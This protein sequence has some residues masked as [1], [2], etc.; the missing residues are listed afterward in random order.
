MSHILSWLTFF[1]LI[2]AVVIAFMPSRMDS[3]VKWVAAATMAVPLVLAAQLLGMF[4]QSSTAF[5]LVEQYDWISSFNIQYHLGVDGLSILMVLLTALIS[6]LAIFASWNIK[7]MVKGYFI[8]LMLLHVGMMGCFLALDFFLFFVF[9]EVMLIPMYFLIGI[10]GGEK[11]EYAAIK[12]F[13]YTMFGGVFMLIGML[14]LYF[15]SADANG[16]VSTFNFLELAKVDWSQFKVAIF[17]SQF[18]VDKLVWWFLFLGFAVKVPVW[19]FHTWLPW[20]HVQAPTAVSIILAG[21]LLKLGTYGFLRVNYQLLPDA[22]LAFKYALVILGVIGVIYGAF[23]ALAQK[24]L[25]K[26][27]AYSSVSHMGYVL[28]GMA[29]LTPAGIQGAVLQMFNHGLSAAMMFMLVGVLYDRLHHRY[30]VTPEGKL[31]FGGIAQKAPWITAIWMVAVFAGMGLPGLNGF[32]SEALIFLG[33]FPVYRTET[34]IMSIGIVLGAAYLLWM[35]QRVFLGP[36]T[37]L[38]KDTST[39]ALHAAHEIQEITGREL[40]VLAPLG[41]LCLWV[42]VYPQPFINLM[43]NTLN[44]LIE[45]VK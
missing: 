33:S 19:P 36:F 28:V 42:G 16:G 37:T 29:V 22:T 41:A 27:V 3:L 10:W 8:M 24:D 26:L 32:I 1:P 4:D 14:A 15:F 38:H 35:V 13:L 17:G 21:V 12:F 34:V 20:A 39:G 2:G 40:I 6:F 31:G 11:K 5:Q 7:K 45:V 18:A 30:I 43:K 25:K 9:W 44:Q 23:C